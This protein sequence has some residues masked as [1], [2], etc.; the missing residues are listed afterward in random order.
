MDPDYNYIEKV[1]KM[2]KYR[3]KGNMFDTIFT[4]EDNLS[5]ASGILITGQENC[6]KNNKKVDLRMGDLSYFTNGTCD[7]NSSSE[8][9]GK[10]RNIIVNNLAVNMKDNEGIIPSLINDISAFEPIEI[11]NSINGSGSVVNDKCSLKKFNIVQLNPGASPYTREVEMC[12]SDITLPVSK[13]L[14]SFTNYSDNEKSYK[15]EII[16]LVIILA[17]ILAFKRSKWFF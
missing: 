5:R 17:G 2:R 1:P 16:F 10:D 13:S 15:N 3:K 8:C 12:V 6:P 7:D 14:E 9:V 4:I 11:V